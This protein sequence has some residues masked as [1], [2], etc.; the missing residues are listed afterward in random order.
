MLSGGE[1]PDRRDY[2]MS[3][4]EAV[5]IMKLKKGH[6][7]VAVAKLLMHWLS[8]DKVNALY[9]RCLPN[10][11]WKFASA[12]LRDLNISLHVDY[13]LHAAEFLEIN[14][15]RE[16]MGNK[17]ISSKKTIRSPFVTVSNHPFGALDG[18]ALLALMGSWVGDRYKLFANEILMHIA[19]M[20]P[21]FIP[22]NPAIS[23]ESPINRHAVITAFRH[24]AE[25]GCL[26]L[27][28]AGCVA[29]LHCDGKIHE[30]A[31]RES[32]MKMVARMQ[33][34]ILPVFFEGRNSWLYHAL[35]LV[36]WRLRSLCLPHEVF[37]KRNEIIHIKVRD[38]IFPATLQDI[39]SP[40]RLQD[41]L[42]HSC[43]GDV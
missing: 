26:G 40:T 25:G 42:R 22:V 11:G 32:L 39:T 35:G 37:V 9:A 20:Q 31:W 36:N 15:K 4:D 33:V 3:V 10:V 24:I 41:F 5:G 18:I 8:V 16:A 34:P 29:R 23:A 1:N 21:S 38:P 13:S 2:V 27:F 6:F 19:A 43:L 14:S 30:E 17:E 28:P 7:G 12:L